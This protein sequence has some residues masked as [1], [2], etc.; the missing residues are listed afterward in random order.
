MIAMFKTNWPEIF[1]ATLLFFYVVKLMRAE[2]INVR[3]GGGWLVALTLL[4]I[5]CLTNWPLPQIA[6]RFGKGSVQAGLML[7]L[8]GWLAL[9]I[10]NNH[11]RISSMTVKLKLLTQELA[12]MQQRLDQMA[13]GQVHEPRDVGGPIVVA[14]TH[15]APAAPLQQT[16]SIPVIRQLVG[17][18]WIVATV[19]VFAVFTGY[20]P[21][22]GKVGEFLTFLFTTLQAEY[23][24]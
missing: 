6:V 13:S 11:V 18:V 5:L 8:I 19:Y 4:V 2:R 15:P 23:L 9:L 3:I 7:L 20:F 22:Q 12:L 24:H 1:L 17:G 10:V 14:A 16:R 21:P